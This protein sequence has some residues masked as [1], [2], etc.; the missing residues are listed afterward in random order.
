MFVR[1]RE[2]KLPKRREDHSTM[3]RQGSKKSVSPCGSEKSMKKKRPEKEKIKSKVPH[4]L[5]GRPEALTIDDF[6]LIDFDGGRPHI[7]VDFIKHM[8][9]KNYYKLCNNAP[10][11]KKHSR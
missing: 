2:K 7:F 11:K 6:L 3:S 5:P 4:I 9:G 8:T 10:P 1:K